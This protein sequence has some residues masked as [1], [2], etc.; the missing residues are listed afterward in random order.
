MP[1]TQFQ[2]LRDATR[3]SIL[4]NWLF[5]AVADAPAATYALKR[6]SCSEHCSLWDFT[7]LGP[8]AFVCSNDPDSTARVGDTR[9]QFR[10][11]VLVV[12]GLTWI[13]CLFLTRMVR[14]C[15]APTVTA[16]SPDSWPIDAPNHRSKSRLPDGFCQSSS[17]KAS[18]GCR[19]Q[20][21]MDR[22]RRVE[23]LGANL[24]RGLIGSM[25]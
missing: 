25:R 1:S 7:L 18:G 17:P 10:A 22:P 4:R 23:L 8:F 24:V 14:C 6:F 20:S 2:M 11:P 13:G 19:I 12:G 16:R 9:K 15:P 5:G 21:A 3:L